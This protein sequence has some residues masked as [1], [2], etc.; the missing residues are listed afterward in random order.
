M[1][2]IDS[3]YPSLKNRNWKYDKSCH[4]FADNL[5][6]LHKFAGSLLLCRSWFQNNPRLPHYD[7]TANKRH[8]AI[9]LGAIEVSR[10]F[11]VKFMKK[12]DQE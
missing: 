1:V 7:L 11:M 10:K 6:E 3:L 12:N 2:Y 9:K 8:H 5:D 4:L